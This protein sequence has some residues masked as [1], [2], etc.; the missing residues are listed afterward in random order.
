MSLETEITLSSADYKN[1]RFNNEFDG[2]CLDLPDRLKVA[3]GDCINRVAERLVD[4]WDR[5]WGDDL[6]ILV[7]VTPRD[8]ILNTLSKEKKKQMKKANRKIDKRQGEIACPKY[9]GITG[10]RK[11]HFTCH[12]LIFSKKRAKVIDVS[13]ARVAMMNVGVYEE[14]RKHLNGDT[15]MKDLNDIHMTFRDK[16]GTGESFM[17]YMGNKQEKINSL[18]YY[19]NNMFKIAKND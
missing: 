1:E 3:K 6:A 5:G 4:W 12:A 11:T 14:S 15:L 2:F 19:I 17:R 10:F 8:E 18:V 7:S 9:H 16:S 13:N